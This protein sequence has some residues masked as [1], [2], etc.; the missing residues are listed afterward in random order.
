MLHPEHPRMTF[1][2]PGVHQQVSGMLDLDQS[3]TLVLTGAQIVS[4]LADA[5]GGGRQR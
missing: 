1:D 3:L 5:H 4:L 2:Q